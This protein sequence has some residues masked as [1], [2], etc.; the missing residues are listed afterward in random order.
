MHLALEKLDKVVIVDG[1]NNRGSGGSA[2]RKQTGV[3]RAET[4]FTV[5]QK[6][7]LWSKFLLN[8][9]KM[10]AKS[11]LLRPQGSYPHLP[12]PP[13]LRH[14]LGTKGLYLGNAENFGMELKESADN[15]R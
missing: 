13:L 5:Y 7:I 2:R 4:I 3:R 14:W 6:M 9:F 10:T 12:P 8:T 11:V 15:L 1:S